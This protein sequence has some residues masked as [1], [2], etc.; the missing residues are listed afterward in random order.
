MPVIGRYIA[1]ILKFV[2]FYMR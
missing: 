2:K 1:E